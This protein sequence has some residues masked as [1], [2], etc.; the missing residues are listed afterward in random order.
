MKSISK[1]DFLSLYNKEILNIIDIRPASIYKK[2]NIL[3]SINIKEL[4]LLKYPSRYLT[5]NK[6]YYIICSKGI[7]S[8]HVVTI[9]NNKGFNTISV[10]GGYDNL[11]SN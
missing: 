1:K 8:Y 6:T 10:I 3:N 9:L 4:L 2:H 11:F 7:S 5:F